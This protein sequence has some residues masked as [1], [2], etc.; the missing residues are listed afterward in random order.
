VR[1]AKATQI[2]TAATASMQTAATRNYDDPPQR[3]S[4]QRERGEH[5]P[6]G[7]D[8]I[9]EGRQRHARSVGSSLLPGAEQEQRRR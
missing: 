9:G 4:R 2:P 1:R 5:D 7:E 8:E 3:G 6:A